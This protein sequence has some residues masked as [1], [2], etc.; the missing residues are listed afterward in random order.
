[1]LIIIT[2]AMR[3][4]KDSEVIGHSAIR[5]GVNLLGLFMPFQTEGLCLY[6][7]FVFAAIHRRS[8]DK[9]VLLLKWLKK[10]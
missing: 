2:S 7:F 8:F 9:M 6:L 10:C 3:F 4:T 5:S 1:M